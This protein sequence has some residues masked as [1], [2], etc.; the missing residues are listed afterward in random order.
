MLAAVQMVYNKPYDIDTER[1][2]YYFLTGAAVQTAQFSTANL[3]ELVS[4]LKNLLAEYS[5]SLASLREQNRTLTTGA[6][7]T[8]KELNATITEARGLVADLKKVQ[9]PTPP[10][11]AALPAA[12]SPFQPLPLPGPKSLQFKFNG[13]TIKI[14][15]NPDQTASIRHDLNAAYKEWVRI[16]W[17]AQLKTLTARDQWLSGVEAA[18][19]MKHLVDQGTPSLPSLKSA[20]TRMKPGGSSSSL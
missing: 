20:I 9:V 12:P 16:H 14:L 1:G 8:Q 18:A 11:Y 4:G 6:I 3:G 10:S 2:L 15:F 13:K 19:L 7:K 5:D 17:L